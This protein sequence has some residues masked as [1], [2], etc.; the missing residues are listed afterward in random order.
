MT[1]ENQRKK[2]LTKAF[3][4]SDS[5]NDLNNTD[6]VDTGDIGSTEDKHQF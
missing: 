2:D 3:K 6:S 5:A 4:K 1:P